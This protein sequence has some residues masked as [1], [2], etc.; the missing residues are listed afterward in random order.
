MGGGNRCDENVK[1][2]KPTFV[3][4]KPKQCSMQR[5]NSQRESCKRRQKLCIFKKKKYIYTDRKRQEKHSVKPRNLACLAVLWLL[6]RKAHR[7]DTQLTLKVKFHAL[8]QK[9]KKHAR[10]PARDRL[11]RDPSRPS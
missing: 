9:K 10:T 2:K 6:V 11:V 4:F 5:E 1:R 8:H 3:R 7:C